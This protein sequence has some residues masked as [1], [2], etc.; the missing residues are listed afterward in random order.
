MSDGFSDKCYG[1]GKII[2]ANAPALLNKGLLVGVN[3]KE[4]TLGSN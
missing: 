4:V 1:N 2:Q 3:V